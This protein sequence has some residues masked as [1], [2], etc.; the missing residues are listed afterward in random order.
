[1]YTVKQRRYFVGNVG[2][3][4]ANLTSMASNGRGGVC[5]TAN[6][7]SHIFCRS[8]FNF[9]GIMSITFSCKTPI[10]FV[11]ENM[12]LNGLL[13]SN[14]SSSLDLFSESCL[15]ESMKF[16]PRNFSSFL[17]LQKPILAAENANAVC[18]ACL[19][20]SSPCEY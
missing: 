13:F 8:T 20:P 18:D 3:F 2:R 1:M 4:L 14:F 5:L 15:S 6:F 11:V 7:F 16:N 17:R 12:A 10:F 9:F 19:L